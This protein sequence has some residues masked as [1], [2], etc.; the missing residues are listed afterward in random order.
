MEKPEIETK[1]IIRFH[2]GYDGKFKIGDNPDFPDISTRFVYFED[3]NVVCDFTVSDEV[4]P[5]LI[6]GLQKYIKSK[7]ETSK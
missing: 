5:S 6:E 7:R 3:E 2:D 4:I 1:I